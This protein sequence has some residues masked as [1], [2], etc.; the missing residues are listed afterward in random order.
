MNGPQLGAGLQL[1]AKLIFE[2][3]IGGQMSL[4][5]LSEIPLP[6]PTGRVG[7]TKRGS[8]IHGHAH[9]RNELQALS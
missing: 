1:I 2:F 8:R 5:T 4:Q 9:V 3:V 6:R 7:D